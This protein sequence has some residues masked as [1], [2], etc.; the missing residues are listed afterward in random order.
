M[1]FTTCRFYFE[2][3]G[4]RISHW[5]DPG[6][7]TK[8]ILHVRSHCTF[9][10]KWNALVLRSQLLTVL[11]IKVGIWQYWP[12]CLPIFIS[13]WQNSTNLV[14]LCLEVQS[15]KNFLYPYS[16]ALFLPSL[17]AIFAVR[18]ADL[19]NLHV[20]F[21]LPFAETFMHR[22]QVQADDIIS[23]HLELLLL[24]NDKN[25]SDFIKDENL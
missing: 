15:L 13:G 18:L 17:P 20:R 8:S 21:L 2:R 10:K 11:W 23:K 16:W 25:F 22:V 12:C 1:P 9:T 19:S 5:D 14:L 6:W 3:I 7:P 24:T 4:Q